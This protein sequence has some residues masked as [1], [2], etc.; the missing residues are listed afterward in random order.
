M[1]LTVSIIDTRNH[2][3]RRCLQIKHRVGCFFASAKQSAKPKDETR[4]YGQDTKNN[5]MKN[6]SK[7]GI[8]TTQIYHPGGI[9]NPAALWLARFVPRRASSGRNRQN[10][11]TLIPEIM[12]TVSATK[13]WPKQKVIVSTSPICLCKNWRVFPILFEKLVSFSH[14]DPIFIEEWILPLNSTGSVLG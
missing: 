6:K 2:T 7:K 5:G 10:L 3:D 1:K 12:K 13:I 4:E 11:L 8:D 9:M 14:V